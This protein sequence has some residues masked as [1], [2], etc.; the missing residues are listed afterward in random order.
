LPLAM[1]AAA[2]FHGTTAH[3]LV[4]DVGQFTAG[5]TC[6]I[7]AASGGVGQILLQLAMQ[8]GAIVLATTSAVEKAAVAR[9]QGADHVFG[10]G[11]GGFVADVLGVTDGRGVDVVFDAIG[12][13]TLRH[14]FQATRKRGLVVNY[15]AVSGA[16]RD[17]DPI[18]LGEAG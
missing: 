14:S 18:E 4:A 15:G 13:D 7:H 2:L 8:A 11:E 9:A 1:A 5:S 17:L 10:Y 3:Y 6:L 12:Q 16:V